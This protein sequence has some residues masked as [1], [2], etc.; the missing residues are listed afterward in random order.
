MPKPEIA[1]DELLV[2]VKAASVNPFDSHAIRGEPACARL[3][4]GLRRLKDPVRGLDVAGVVEA[5]GASV[6]E[7]HPGDEVFG[8]RFPRSRSHAFEL[9]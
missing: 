3:L 6:T 1:D 2:R 9:P 4:V 8:R 7:F 5:V